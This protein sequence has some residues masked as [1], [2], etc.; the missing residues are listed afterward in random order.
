MAARGSDPFA[1]LFVSLTGQSSVT[2]PQRESVHRVADR[3][4]QAIGDY[5]R[6]A[7]LADG[8]DD[9]LAEPDAE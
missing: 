9:A 7:A 6:A 4:E 5:L 1:A 2:E 3:D 8:L